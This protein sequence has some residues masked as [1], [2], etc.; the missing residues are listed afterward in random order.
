MMFRSHV[1]KYGLDIIAARKSIMLAAV[2]QI[3][4]IM[5][6]T[7]TGYLAIAAVDSGSGGGNGGDGNGG[8]G[9]D[10]GDSDSGG[11]GGGGVRGVIDIKFSR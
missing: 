11:G 10:G 5:M 2:I 7:G 3:C 8:D 9:G 6:C 4:S 1:R